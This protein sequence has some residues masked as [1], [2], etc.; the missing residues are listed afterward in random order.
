MQLHSTILR[1]R[2]ADRARAR[3]RRAALRGD[4][5]T[6]ALGVAMC[7]AILTP[8][9]ALAWRMDEIAA[10]ARAVCRIL[11]TD[12]FGNASV[13]GSG[14][15]MEQAMRN[16]RFPVAWEALDTEGDC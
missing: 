14:S 16:A 11:V 4:L 1:Q 10:D 3:Q 2:R 13:A 6:M 7:G 12:G 9:F 8:W 15:D 5:I